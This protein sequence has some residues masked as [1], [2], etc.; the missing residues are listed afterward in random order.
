MAAKDENRQQAPSTKQGLCFDFC[1]GHHPDE[2]KDT[3]AH[4]P[5]STIC[6]KTTQNNL[7]HKSTKTMILCKSDAF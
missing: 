5:L 4:F 1:A 2:A 3:P 7:S 6:E